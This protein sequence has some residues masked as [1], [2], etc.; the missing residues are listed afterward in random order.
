[1]EFRNHPIIEG[2]SV[3][4][5]GK[6][7]T[8]QGSKLVPFA[9][10]R[11]SKGLRVNFLGKSHSV[12]KLVCEAWNGLRPNIGMRVNRIDGDF[13]NYHY[14]NL[15]WRRGAANGFIKPKLTIEDIEKILIM[16][17][18]GYKPKEIAK[19][20]NVSAMHIGRIKKKYGKTD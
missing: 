7:I 14:K 3:S 16:A 13:N 2:L 11:K 8:Y 5:D 12:L 6:V 19:E 18:A 17:D 10:Q 1:M 15:E 4:E 20:F 9:N